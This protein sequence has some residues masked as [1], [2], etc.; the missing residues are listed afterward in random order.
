M[1]ITTYN[2]KAAN[3]RHIRK[4][5]QVTLDDGRTIHFTE[6]LSKK[7]AESQTRSLI[8]RESIREAITIARVQ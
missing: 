8:I 3:G 2:L 4:A 6:R 1:T 5:T 7:E